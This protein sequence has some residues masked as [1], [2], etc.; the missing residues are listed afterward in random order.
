[1]RGAGPTGGVPEVSCEWPG[2]FVRQITPRV[3]CQTSGGKSVTRTLKSALITTLSLVLL[4]ATGST[5]TA[6]SGWWVPI[7]TPSPESEVNAIGEPHRGTDANGDVVGYID[8]HTHMFMDLG[9][10]GNAVCGSTWS[11]QGIA[12]ALK[13]CDRHRVS[14]LENLTNGDA[15]RG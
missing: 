8:A 11:E 6:E 5:A 2:L 7:S 12:D 4:L 1:P 13:G 10:G 3:P 9:M 15:G 14:I